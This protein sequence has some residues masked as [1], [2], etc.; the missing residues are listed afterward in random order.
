MDPSTLPS[1]ICVPSAVTRA[2]EVEKCAS[3]C[4]APSMSAR[5]FSCL[6]RIMPGAGISRAV[7]AGCTAE[8]VDHQ[9]GVVGE[10][11]H[12]VTVVDPAGFHKEH[13]PRV[14]RRSQGYR[15]DS[16][17]PQAGTMSMLSPMMRRASSSLC[18]LLVANTSRFHITI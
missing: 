18:L 6:P 1:N 14:Y 2:T 17:F 10:A 3:R 13:S 12:T 4:S 15:R 11:V 7:H 5:S 8:G 9:S 16:L